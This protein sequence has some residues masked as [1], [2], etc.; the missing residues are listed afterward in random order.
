MRVDDLVIGAVLLLGPEY[1]RRNAAPPS[2][3]SQDGHS[4]ARVSL[5]SIGDQHGSQRIHATGWNRR[6]GVRVRAAGM[7]ASPGLRRAERRGL[8]LRAAVG[9]PLGLLGSAD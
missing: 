1:S 4:R 6:R 8:L 3:V 9:P 2:A 5:P 7:D